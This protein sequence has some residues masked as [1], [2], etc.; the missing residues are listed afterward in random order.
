MLRR[1]VRPQDEHQRLHRAALQDGR[2]VP[3]RKEVRSMI[4]FMR[5]SL[6]FV[7]T[8]FGHWDV[9]IESENVFMCHDV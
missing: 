6:E 7:M 4:Q 1:F 5:S 3:H 2:G 9:A 8:S